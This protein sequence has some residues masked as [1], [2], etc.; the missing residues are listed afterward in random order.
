[1]MNIYGIKILPLST[2]I[3]LCHVK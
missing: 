1:M 2:E 3:S